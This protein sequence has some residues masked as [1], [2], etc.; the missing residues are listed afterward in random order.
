MSKI[1]LLTLGEQY[2]EWQYTQLKNIFMD[3]VEIDTYSNDFNEIEEIIE[4][5]LYISSIPSL[6]HKAIDVIPKNS[7]VITP[8]TTITNSAYDQILEIP[9]GTTVL[10]VNDTFLSTMET[11]ILLYNLGLDHLKYI[12]YYPGLEF[13][14]DIEI[15]IT[16][17]EQQLVPDAIEEIINIEHRVFD[18]DTLTEIAIILGL[19]SILRTTHFKNHLKKIKVVKD[20]LVSQ[21]NNTSVIRSQMLSLLNVMD[22]GILIID[23]KGKISMFNEKAL[24]VIGGKHNFVTS[25]I[26]EIIPEIYY[27]EVFETFQPTEYDLIRIGSKDISVKVVPVND[28]E[29]STS[30]VVIVNDFH[31]KEETQ[32]KLRA[33]LRRRKNSAKYTFRDIISS[34]AKMIGIKD[35]SRRQVSSDAPVLILGES[36]TGK[37]MFAQAIHNASNRRKYPFFAVNCAALPES[38]LESEL[39]GYEEGSFTGAKKGGKQG[40][41]E[42]AHKG[43]IF[44]DEIGEMDL[45]LQA[46][47]LRV[48]EEREVIR[49]GGN[50][51]IPIDIKV[52]SATNKPLWKLVSEKKFR[53]DLFYRVNVLPIKIPPLRE[54]KCD[55]P[56]L[57]YHFKKS[58]NAN[59]NLTSKAMS[60]LNE[61]QWYGNL[62]ELRNCVDYL[63]SLGKSKIEA[64]DL[65]NILQDNPELTVVPTSNAQISTIDT[66][67]TDTSDALIPTSTSSPVVVGLEL[68]S[69]FNM[70]KP[71][72]ENYEFI[73]ECLYNSF[74]IKKRIGRRSMLQMSQERDLFLTE[75]IIRKMLNILELHGLVRL[76][77]GRG[78]TMITQLGIKAYN[79][80]KQN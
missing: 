34:D 42:L 12:P 25:R 66:I 47:L 3:K 1:A 30:A 31:T 67:T 29:K 13:P 59:F 15:A 74:I 73:L 24:S 5:D 78:G 77:N 56:I 79:A 27:R 26:H 18:A 55:I 50:K 43:T 8:T 19:Q 39:F 52:I 21:F 17:S 64:E 49:I 6:H 11:T 57:V 41:F 36:G 63:A 33:K 76:S 60:V 44:L 61:Y 45:G 51:T 9:E 75:N 53:Q 71:E 68:Q 14:D 40:Y 58:I 38:L 72:I 22:D 7:K 37:E 62:R 20:N 2:A 28:A 70:I 54:R 65:K 4:A 32:H 10:L 23:N 80:L 35:L 69:F 48:L 46:R 16:P